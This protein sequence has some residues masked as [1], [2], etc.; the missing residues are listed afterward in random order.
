VPP[1]LRIP[2]EAVHSPVGFAHR[3]LTGVLALVSLRGVSL[4]LS[5]GGLFGFESDA[6][7]QYWPRYSIDSSVGTPRLL[8]ARRFLSLHTAIVLPPLMIA[9]MPKATMSPTRPC[10]YPNYRR[11]ISSLPCS[12]LLQPF[13]CSRQV[14][15]FLATMALGTRQPSPSCSIERH[16]P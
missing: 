9:G 12:Q 15:G 10:I 11:P 8:V 1:A 6:N 5:M 4:A 2:A 13:L 3:C 16:R 14:Q 7:A